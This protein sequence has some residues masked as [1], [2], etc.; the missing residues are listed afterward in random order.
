MFKALESQY[1]F[2]GGSYEEYI[3]YFQRRDCDQGLWHF[4]DGSEVRATAGFSVVPKKAEGR[5]RKLLMQ[6]PAN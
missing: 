1:G 2:V 6:V 5:Q 4:V 3:K